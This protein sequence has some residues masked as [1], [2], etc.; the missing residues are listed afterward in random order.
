MAQGQ[1]AWGRTWTNTRGP[2]WQ[3]V[4]RG[5]GDDVDFDDA[6]GD[7]VLDALGESDEHSETDAA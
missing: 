2:G 4:A 1:L 7:D 6:F 3:Q 5:G